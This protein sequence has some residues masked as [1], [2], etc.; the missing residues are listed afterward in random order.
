[1]GEVKMLDPYQILLI[2]ML[3]SPINKERRTF[4]NVDIFI[5]ANLSILS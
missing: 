3:T 5:S 4:M 2:F 1:M